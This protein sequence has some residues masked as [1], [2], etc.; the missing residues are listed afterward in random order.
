MNSQKW[1]RRKICASGTLRA[2]GFLCSL[3]AWESIP[4]NIFQCN[5]SKDGLLIPVNLCVEGGEAGTPDRPGH[6]HH[7]EQDH[8][9][10]ALSGRHL[11]H[12]TH[13]AQDDTGGI[14]QTICVKYISS[15]CY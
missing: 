8:H 13:T 3:L 10:D 9:G 2:Q 5:L 14:V 11:H 1:R 7:R 15:N 4:N 12:H 6:F